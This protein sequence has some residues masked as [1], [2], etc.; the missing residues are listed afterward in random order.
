MDA[1]DTSQSKSI[2]GNFQHQYL[3]EL[4]VNMY[5]YRWKMKNVFCCCVHGSQ[6]FSNPVTYC[7]AKYSSIHMVG[8]SQL[9]H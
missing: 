6:L 2:L 5:S 7:A 1:S 9:V 4:L 3:P 8:L